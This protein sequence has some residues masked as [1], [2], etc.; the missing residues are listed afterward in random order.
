ME[1]ICRG[2]GVGIAGSID[3]L[4]VDTTTNLR[5]LGTKERARTANWDQR[6]KI[7]KTNRC[8]QQT[9]HVQR[10]QQIAEHGL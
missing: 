8:R 2:E 6:V 10:H 5:R 9:V 1:N 7:T 4:G 3:Y